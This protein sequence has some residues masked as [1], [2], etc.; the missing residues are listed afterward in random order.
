MNAAV[1]PRAAHGREQ[2]GVGAGGRADEDE[3]ERRARRAGRRSRPPSRSPR[4]VP[5][6]RFVAKTS[7]GVALA[8]DVVQRDEAELA[9]MA[10]RA[11][12]DDA[13]RVE[14]R[15]ELLG[16]SDSARGRATSTS[17]S[18]ATGRPSTT[19]S[20]LTS[21][22]TTSGSASA[23]RLRPSR[24]VDERVAI[25]GRLAAERSEQ[26]LGAQVVDHLLGVD[27]VERHEP[28]AARRR[29]PR[30]GS[31][32][33]PSI[34][35]GPN[36]ASVCTPAISSRVPRTIGAT[37]SSTGTVVGR[38]PR[39]A[40]PSA[41][42]AHR[43]GSSAEVRAARGRARSCARS[44]RRR[45]SPRP[46]SRAPRRRP[47]RRPAS[48][49]CARAAPGRRTRQQALRADFRERGHRRVD[50]SAGR[51][52]PS[53]AAVE[54]GRRRSWTSSH[55]AWLRSFQNSSRS[56]RLRSLPASVRGSSSRSS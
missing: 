7:P 52:R 31:R 27:A 38:A 46:G 32:R 48:P 23:S 42:R 40:A 45:A 50:V 47:P 35:H 21:T 34:T 24:I 51:R 29:S 44:R 56:T 17:A 37:S 13:A 22:A 30:R 33:S 55:T 39:R 15:P 53:T 20:G 11:G 28:E 2:L 6:S 14:Q 3:V 10:R 36:C 4:I 26:R 54:F 12:D 5:P 8:E 19:I 49:R 41:A 18:T 25:D 9:R 1:I 16:A 43:V